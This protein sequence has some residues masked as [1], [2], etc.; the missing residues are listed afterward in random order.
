MKIE[1]FPTFFQ[2]SRTG[3][4]VEAPK[5]FANGAKD[6]IEF[7]KSKGWVFTERLYND[8]EM[9][10]TWSIHNSI[11][12]DFCHEEW[13]RDL[14]EYQ[15][16]NLK[17][18]ILKM[19]EQ[20]GIISAN[21]G[22]LPLCD[23]CIFCG[24]CYKGHEHRKPSAIN[25]QWSLIEAPW[26][27]KNYNKNKIVFLGIN[28]NEDGGLEELSVLVNAAREK[29]NHD[30]V[31]VDFGYHYP[32]GRKYKGTFLWHR[33]AA[34][35]KMVNG[36]LV[37][38]NKDVDSML[39]LLKDENLLPKNVAN[40]FDNIAFLNHIKCSPHGERSQPTDRMWENCGRHILLAELKILRPQWIVVLGVGDNMWAFLKNVLA[41]DVES[42]EAGFKCCITKAFN[43]KT[44]VI[45][46]PHP[47]APAGGASKKHYLTLF[48]SVQS[49]KSKF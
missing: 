32:D 6:F 23:H 2:M 42:I 26:I 20:K 29:L 38:G 41:N 47:A 14:G 33:I 10:E 1:E 28:P 7:M 34:Y 24:E 43:T 45:A 13:D 46:V 11:N 44:K 37:C 30:K 22:A 40:E 3:I 12:S 5:L 49:A 15:S 16:Y 4:N 18:L 25:P 31:K 35:S 21:R 48:N 27:G 36:A 17:E 39:K 19:Y 8:Y 9:S